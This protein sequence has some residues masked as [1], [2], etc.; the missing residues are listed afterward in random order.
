MCKDQGSIAQGLFGY[1]GSA[2]LYVK[3]GDNNDIT[4]YLN[5]QPPADRKNGFGSRDATKF[6]EFSSQKRTEQFRE[7]MRNE[8]RVLACTAAH[9]SITAILDKWEHREASRLDRGGTFLYDIGRSR[10]TEFDSKKSK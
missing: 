5:K 7:S 4:K 6:D 9:P 2:F 10:T 1:H 8:K 3:S